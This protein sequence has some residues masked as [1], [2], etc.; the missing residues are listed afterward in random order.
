MVNGSGGR[1]SPRLKCGRLR[2]SNTTRHSKT[3]VQAG[4][5]CWRRH[6]LAFCGFWPAPADCAFRLHIGPPTSPGL[7]SC[8]QTFLGP[9]AI[10]GGAI[11]YGSGPPGGADPYKVGR[12]QSPPTHAARGLGR[13][14]SIDVRAPTVP[15]SIFVLVSSVNRSVVGVAI[16]GWDCRTGPFGERGD[17]G[18]KD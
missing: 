2:G 15:A 10:W 16:L 9:K 14:R 17:D 4:K 13:R 5:L 11:F 7:P 3:T 12:S 6:T 1:R 18:G 8:V